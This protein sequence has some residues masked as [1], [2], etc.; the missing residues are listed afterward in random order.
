MYGI[1][2]AGQHRATPRLVCSQ[3]SPVFGLR[4]P[5]FEVFQARH[6][7]F[8]F[9][10]RVCLL[11]APL[12]CCFNIYL[13][14]NDNSEEFKMIYWLHESGLRSLYDLLKFSKFKGLSLTLV[15]KLTRNILVNLASLRQSNVDVIH[16]DLKPENVMLIKHNEYRIK[17]IDFGSSCSS[18]HKPF[19]YIQ[20]RF[21]R[22]P[23]VL[24]CRWVR[25]RCSLE[26]DGDVHLSENEMFSSRVRMRCFLLG[27][28]WEVFL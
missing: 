1:C 9:S 23:E 6:H 20:S 13:V 11:L 22:S 2:G 21:Y 12:C 15:R 26:C 5:P 28:E 16:C 7:L 14:L 24:L 25:I 8:L 17:V 18:S 3:K 4:T 27:W 19:S 10:L